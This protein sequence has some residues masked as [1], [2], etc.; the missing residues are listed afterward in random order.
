MDINKIEKKYGRITEQLKKL[1]STCDNPLSRMA[2]ITSLLQNKFDYYY[3]TGFYLLSDDKL[4]VG[5]Y[6][7][8]LACMILPKNTGVCWASVT[9]GKTIIVPDVHSFPGHI[10]CDS[11]TN[12]E[13]VI[14]LFNQNNVVGVLDVDSIIPDAF[15]KIDAQCLE[16]ITNLVYHF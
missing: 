13:I 4:Q 12:A 2:T 9:S 11:K 5:P 10:A 16:E 8:T 14:P 3:W 15:N 7:G 1:F 6:Q